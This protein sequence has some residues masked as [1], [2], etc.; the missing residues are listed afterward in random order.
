MK[1]SAS[2]DFNR[3]QCEAD[4]AEVKQI[5]EEKTR[6]EE[7]DSCLQPEFVSGHASAE[8]RGYSN[9]VG[10]GEADDDG[11]QHIFNIGDDPVMCLGG[12]GDVLLEE[13]S[14]IADGEEQQEARDEF[15][16]SRGKLS[17]GD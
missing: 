8:D 11:P 14:G 17:D 12:T 16:N 1:D 10:D 13:F 15:N 7:D 5:A 3:D 2:V 9:G 4:A 6:S